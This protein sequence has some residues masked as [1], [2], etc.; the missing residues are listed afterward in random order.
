MATNWVATIFL[1]SQPPATG[2]YA[3]VRQLGGG[4]SDAAYNIALDSNNNVYVGANVVPPGGT[5][6]VHFSPTEIMPIQPN[7]INTPSDYYKRSFLVKYNSNGQFVWKRAMQGI[8]DDI[9]D[10]SE[11][12]KILI[13]SNDVI[14]FIVGILVVHI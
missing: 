10:R 9:L 2:R 8:T 5:Y 13:D 3:G 7:P 1:F 12:L 11:I 14:H 6:P 4:L